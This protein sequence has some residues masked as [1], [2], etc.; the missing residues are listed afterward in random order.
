MVNARAIIWDEEVLQ[1]LEEIA[2]EFCMKKG[3]TERF[4][5]FVRYILI[6]VC[7]N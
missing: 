7:E 3:G 2:E 4:R 1:E 6:D 5:P